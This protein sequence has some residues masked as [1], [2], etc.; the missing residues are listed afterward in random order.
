VKTRLAG[1]AINLHPNAILA[2]SNI[3][4]QAS[5][6]QKRV[7][8]TVLAAVVHKY[9]LILEAIMVDLI[10]CFMPLFSLI[11]DTTMR[12]LAL[13]A[14]ALVDYTVRNHDVTWLIKHFLEFLLYTLQ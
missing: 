2:H 5:T 3:L 8:W 11:S 6:S 7:R 14:I 12:A 1:L 13:T 9:S 10:L 4:L